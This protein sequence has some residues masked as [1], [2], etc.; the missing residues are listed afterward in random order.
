MAV[1][2]HPFPSRTRQLSSLALKILG[3]KRPGKIRRCRHKRKAVDIC[4][5]L[6]FSLLFHLLFNTHLFYALRPRGPIL[7]DGRK[8][9]KT[10]EGEPFRWVPLR[11]PLLTD[12]RQH[13]R[14]PSVADE[15]RKWWAQRSASRSARLRTSGSRAPQE[16]VPL[17]NPSYSHHHRQWDFC[18]LSAGLWKVGTTT[19]SETK[20]LLLLRQRK[21][22]GLSAPPKEST[23]PKEC[24]HFWREMLVVLRT[25][26]A[27]ISNI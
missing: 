23:K 11:N 24:V 21:S 25:L 7:S 10:A 26:P 6:F 9:A 20:M 19:G 16:K 1:R 18:K 3:W 2:V 4:P 15:G 12:Q 13:F 8:D 14:P 22:C 5:L 27:G 17:W